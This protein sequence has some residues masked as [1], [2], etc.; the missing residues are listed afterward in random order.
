MNAAFFED[1][2]DSMDQGRETPGRTAE[3]FRMSRHRTVKKRKRPKQA[4]G[5]HKRRQKRSG[6]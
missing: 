5:F 3:R 1:R 4:N 2:D 6:L